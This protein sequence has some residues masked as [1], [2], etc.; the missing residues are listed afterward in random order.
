MPLDEIRELLEAWEAGACAD[1]RTRLRPL[2]AARI[3][4]AERRIA[5]L[6]AFAAHLATVHEKLDGPAPVDVCGPGC[7][8]VAAEP[9]EHQGP[10][11]PVLIELTGPV[12]G[13]TR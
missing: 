8:C 10:P 1:V 4:E 6:T 11:G 2:V 5:E 12:S 3:A 7:G 13:A 9:S